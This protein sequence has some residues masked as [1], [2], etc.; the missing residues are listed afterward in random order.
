MVRLCETKILGKSKTMLHGTDSFRVNIKTEEIYS[1][2]AKY[3][4]AKYNASNYE[5]DRPLPKGK[6]QKRLD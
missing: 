1:D 5:L 2:I 3:V 6:K 4:K